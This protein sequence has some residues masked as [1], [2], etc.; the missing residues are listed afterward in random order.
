MTQVTNTTFA[1]RDGKLWTNYRGALRER[2]C[3]AD[4][5]GYRYTQICRN[6]RNTRMR[7][8]RVIADTF[9]EKPTGIKTEVCH[10]NDIKSDD[11]VENLYWG[12]HSQN[13]KDA[14]RNGCRKPTRKLSDLDV[15]SIRNL[16]SSG[17]THASIAKSFNVSQGHVTDIVNGR[18][19]AHGVEIEFT[20]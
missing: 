5:L 4:K 17:K 1:T 10:R 2:M 3:W 8:C 9:I 15:L 13:G 7:V 20:K 12:T 11:R 16:A 19:R 6:G 18:K 14:Y